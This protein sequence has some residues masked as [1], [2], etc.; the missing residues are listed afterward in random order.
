MRDVSNWMLTGHG[1]RSTLKML[2]LQ[3]PDGYNYYI[4]FPRQFDG[5]RPNLEDIN[6]VIA[7]K[8]AELLGIKSVSAEI[9]HFQG[10]RVCLMRDFIEEN[11]S[12][13]GEHAGSLFEVE[14]EEEYTYISQSDLKDDE[15]IK[16]IFSLVRRFSHYKIIRKDFIDMN[17]FDLLIGNQDRH[18]YNWQILYDSSGN[19]SFGPLYDNGASLAWQLPDSSLEIYI[20]QKSKMESYFN[21]MKV[22]AGLDEK[23]SPR[24][25]GTLLLA[26]LKN[27][28]SNDFEDFLIRLKKFNMDEFYD[29]IQ[30][31][32]ELSDIRIEFLMRFIEVRREILL[33]SE[34]LNDE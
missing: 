27:S 31:L 21:K 9:A 32:P 24:I 5:K 16:Y 25:R 11:D 6:E 12:A 29:F 14:F 34:V 10:S 7:A 3:S 8:I 28:F 18:P 22:K 26:Y 33:R 19:P 23:E 2:T 1:E 4:K 13:Q 17:L 15:L 20:K 30:Q